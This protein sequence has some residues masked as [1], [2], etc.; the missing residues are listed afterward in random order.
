MHSE[1]A[2]SAKARAMFAD[3]LTARNYTEML[4]CKDVHDVAAYLKTKTPYGQYLSGLNTSTVHRG[5]LEE[6]LK[7]ILFRE[8]DALS[9]YDFALGDKFYEYFIISGEILQITRCISLINTGSKDKY[10]LTLPEFFVDRATLDLMSLAKAQTMRDILEVLKGG[11]YYDICKRFIAGN[12]EDIDLV[13]MSKALDEYKFNRLFEIINSTTKGGARKELNNF[14]K[15]LVDIYNI[16][17]LERNNRFKRHSS[18]LLSASVTVPGGAISQQTLAEMSQA[19]TQKELFEMVK[20]TKYKKYIKD[21][22]YL[23]VEMLTSSMLYNKAIHELRFSPY[24]LVVMMAYASLAQT[25][26]NNVVH[27][28]EGIRYNVQPERIASILVGADK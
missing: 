7:N 15:M 1:N 4:Q 24:P 5:W 21:E 26:I 6:N 20:N 3:R 13:N 14:A 9:H 27:I 19:R 28:V 18:S 12:R 16:E 11:A 23:F 8:L 22:E 25:E 10:L 17:A 2:I